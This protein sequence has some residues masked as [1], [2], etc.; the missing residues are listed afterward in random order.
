MLSDLDKTLSK[1]SRP[2]REEE[3]RRSQ[4]SM[5]TRTTG[6]SQSINSNLDDSVR[7]RSALRDEQLSRTARKYLCTDFTENLQMRED[8]QAQVVGRRDV[9]YMRQLMKQ[10][11][12]VD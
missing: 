4:R 11:Q 10:Q 2:Q 6:V 8:D 12:L 3:S 9:G 5:N 1:S 7:N